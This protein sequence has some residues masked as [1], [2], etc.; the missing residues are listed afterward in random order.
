MSGWKQMVSDTEV[1]PWSSLKTLSSGK[2]QRLSFFSPALGLR[3]F[4]GVYKT[5]GPRLPRFSTPI[6]YLFRGHFSEWFH[7]AEDPSRERHGEGYWTLVELIQSAVDKGEFPPCLLVFPDFGGDGRNGLTLAIDWK[8]PELARKGNF[9]GGGLGAFETSFRT[10]FL[11]RFEEDLG[12]IK[13]R[14]AAIGFSL[15]GFNAVQLSMRNPALFQIVAAYDGSFPFHPVTEDDN[16]LKH[17]LF[18]PIFGR[19]PD[20]AH[21][22]SHSPAWLARNLPSSQLKKMKFF[23]ASGPESSEPTDSNYYRNK[24]VVDSL[25]EQGVENGIE[26]V[27]EEGRHDWYTADTFAF[28]VLMKVWG[29]KKDT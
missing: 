20:L 4:V 27:V 2:I 3:R 21:L 7:A 29:N 17:H 15:G 19:P 10:E 16:I 24:A 1:I 11:A 9:V 13:P 23:L 8:A 25:A 14:R 26:M 28:R 12:L 18:D 5:S 6:V 22:K